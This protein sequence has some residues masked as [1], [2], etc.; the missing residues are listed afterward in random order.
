MNIIM[1][2]PFIWFM[3]NFIPRCLAYLINALIIKFAGPVSHAAPQV[4]RIDP[5]LNENIKNVY[6]VFAVA[7]L[8]ILIWKKSSPILLLWR[9]AGYK[10]KEKVIVNSVLRDIFIWTLHLVIFY[11][12]GG[13]LWGF[14]K[15]D[16]SACVHMNWHEDPFMSM[17]YMLWSVTVMG[18]LFGYG[19]SIFGYLFGKRIKNL[20]FT[21]M[22]WVTNAVCYGPLLGVVIFQMTPPLVGL[23]PLIAQGPLKE[24]VLI[25]ELILNLLYTISIWNLGTMFGIMTDKGVRTSGFYSV[26]RHPSYTLE[27]LMFVM[28]FFNGLSSAAQCLT[29]SMFLLTYFVRSEREDQFMSA[30]NPDYR[31]YQQKPLLNLF[32]GS[33]KMLKEKP[34]HLF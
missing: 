18:C 29:I 16:L 3:V 15:A 25:T 7:Y 22:G 11:A 13:T 34:L 24:L 9:W 21:V 6:I 33:I 19:Y 31:L 20:D 5:W 17:R 27:S 12:F 14:L 32:Q 1:G 23:D 2:V 10:R 30:S 8:L 4:L 26:V 28:V